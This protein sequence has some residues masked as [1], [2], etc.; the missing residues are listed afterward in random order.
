MF[1]ALM[2]LGLQYEL[3]SLRFYCQPRSFLIADV[4]CNFQDFARCLKGECGGTRFTSRHCLMDKCKPFVIK[5]SSPDYEWEEVFVWCAA[6]C[7]C[8]D[9]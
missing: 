8:G 3:L 9:E 2:F 5:V 1:Q 4:L 6:A 7:G